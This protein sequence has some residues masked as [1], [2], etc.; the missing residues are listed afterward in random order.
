MSSK[1]EIRDYIKEQAE[2]AERIQSLLT[3][4][5]SEHEQVFY[6]SNHLVSAQNQRNRVSVEINKL[7]SIL[8]SNKLVK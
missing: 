6:T 5:L 2:T 3:T 1:E 4:I 7:I 8:K